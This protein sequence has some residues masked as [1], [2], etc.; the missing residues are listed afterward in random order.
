MKAPPAKRDDGIKVL[1]KAV[2]LLEALTPD[3]PSQPLGAIARTV[4]L[5][6]ATARRILATLEEQ[7]LV[8]QHP[9]TREYS[10]GLRLLELGSRVTHGL[11]LRQVA[12]PI[13]SELAA[14]A[15]ESVYLGVYDAGD[16]VYIEIVECAHQ[17]RLIVRVGERLPAHVAGTGKVLLAN[18]PPEELHAFLQRPLERY[19][20][21]SE[22]SVAALQAHL[23]MIASRG[24]DI[25]CDEH[26][27][28]VSSV[29]APIR[30]PGG[31]V[32]A[33]LSLCGPSS[34]LPEDQLHRLAPR[35][36]AAAQQ[37]S[38]AMGYQT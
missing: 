5:N 37:I 6:S 24:Y 12:R 34:R 11:L 22:A 4:G 21:N 8:A 10:L 38:T 2:Q 23:Q 35:V 29:A 32:I 1:R 7:G 13:M 27:P 30:D 33:A 18:V 14:E 20:A 31:S 25:S 28:G 15:D 36:M 26:L 9:S 19:T 16:V 17:L 3:R